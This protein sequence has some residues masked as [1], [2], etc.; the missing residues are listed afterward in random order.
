MADQAMASEAKDDWRPQAH[1]PFE[2]KKQQQMQLKQQKLHPLHNIHT[3]V[4][5]VD[6]VR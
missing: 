2:Q 6:L 3:G 1:P 4:R 5:Y